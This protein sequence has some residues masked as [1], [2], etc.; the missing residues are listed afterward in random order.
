MEVGLFEIR[1]AG[2]PAKRF[3]RGEITPKNSTNDYFDVIHAAVPLGEIEK[4][5]TYFEKACGKRADS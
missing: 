4:A 2:C 3:E 5:F 1:V